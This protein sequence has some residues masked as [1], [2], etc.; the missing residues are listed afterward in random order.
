MT[1]VRAMMKEA[2]KSMEKKITKVQQ[3]EAMV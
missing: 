1:F 3:G 2:K